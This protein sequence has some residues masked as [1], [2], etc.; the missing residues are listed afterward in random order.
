MANP[1]YRL[2]AED[3]REQIESGSLRSDQQLPTEIELREH[4]AASRNTVR[5]AIKW[6]TMLGLVE[7]RPGQ[8]T[9][10][11]T[12]IA[13]FIRTPADDPKDASGEQAIT[14]VEVDKDPA[15]G[16]H[17]PTVRRRELG[18]LLRKLRTQ[19]GLTVEQAAERLLFSVGKLSR[20]ETGHGVAT[21]R[22]IRDLCD[23]YG[24]TDE[25]ER[26]HMFKLAAEGK[27][28]AWWLSYDLT[29]ANYVG[30]EA[31]ANIT[32]A[33]EASAIH[34][35]LQIADYPGAVHECALPE[36]G[37]DYIEMQIEA[38]LTWWRTVTL[39]L[40]SV[41]RYVSALNS[42]FD[43]DGPFKTP[44]NSGSLVR[45]QKAVGNATAQA[46]FHIGGSGLDLPD[47]LSLARQNLRRSFATI[48][49]T[50]GNQLRD[51]GNVP[52]ILRCKRTLTAP[53][54]GRFLTFLRALEPF[55]IKP[56]H[57]L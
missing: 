32:S 42:L 53:W 40:G 44:P 23:L 8:G 25:A 5:D 47:S 21:S 16:V 57:Q 36:F 50:V 17:S 15:P 31:E 7:T 9:F 27:Q 33:F 20:M 37:P 18:A 43:G 11:V 56:A 48:S 22:H 3:L 24:V 28:Q 29:Y 39:T 10:V 19:K 26:A 45:I 14:D 1:V 2:I 38:K 30:R 35:F 6:L 54:T 4:Y 52:R 49:P 13:S 34:G 51:V 46:P 55:P 41:L 12:T